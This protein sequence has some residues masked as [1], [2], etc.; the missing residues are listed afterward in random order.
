MKRRQL[1]DLTVSAI[2]LGCMGMSEFYG[3]ADEDESIATIQRALELGVTLP[4]HRRRVRL[5][6]NEELVGER[7]SPAGATRSSWPPSSASRRDERPRGDRR[8]PRVR[9]AR[10]ARRRCAG[11]ASTTSTSTTCTAATRTCRSRRASG[12]MAELVAA[13]KVAPPRPE[14][15]RTPTRCAPPTP[16][17]RSRRCRAS[18]RCSRA[19]SSA[20]SSR[21]ARELGVGIVPYSPLGRGRADRRGRH[22][23]RRRRLP[24]QLA[25]LPGAAT[26]SAT[27]QR[28]E[29]ADGDR[30]RGRLHAGPARA[31]VAAAPGRRRGADPGHHGTPAGWRRT[32]P[33]SDIELTDEQLRALD[34][35]FRAGRDRAGD[36]YADMA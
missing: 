5:G 34:E 7:R 15:G 35:A 19:S 36:R 24:P 13:G 21:P 9:S 25:A 10:R 17:T 3:P 12:A 29:P 31:G 16:C 4:R 1:R 23:R 18:G 33:R 11:S 14:R 26:A 30:R 8:Q 6:H 27:S 2:G 28:V 22:R 20:R 32:R